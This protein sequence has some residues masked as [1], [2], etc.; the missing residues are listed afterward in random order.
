MFE[1][2]ALPPI[3]LVESD[4]HVHPPVEKHADESIGL[5]SF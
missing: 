5:I 1:R 2:T 4:V 3:E